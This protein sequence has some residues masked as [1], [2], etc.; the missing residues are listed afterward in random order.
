MRRTLSTVL[1]VL[2]A[3]AMLAGCLGGEEDDAVGSQS[4]QELAETATNETANETTELEDEGPVIQRA[5]HNG[6][7]EGGATALGW[8]C[9]P[10]SECDNDLSFEVPNGTQAILVEAAWEAEAD[11]YLS[12]GG[13]ECEPFLVVFQSCSPSDNAQG[14]SP[15][16]VRFGEEDAGAAGT[17]QATIWVDETTPT[18]I[19]PTIVASVVEDGQLPD[20]YSA[21]E[22]A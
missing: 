5:W 7:L 3:T 22:D 1:A 8:Y 18:Q 21:L 16:E 12:V 19:E 2:V 20:G 11:A 14:S 13:P 6:S 15:L 17:W 10:T 4:S 9:T